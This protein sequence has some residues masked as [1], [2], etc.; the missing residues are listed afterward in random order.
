DKIEEPNDRGIVSTLLFQGAC[1]SS[2]YLRVP[3]GI[4][5]SDI[6]LR[7]VLQIRLDVQGRVPLSGEVPR[8]ANRAFD[9]LLPCCRAPWLVKGVAPLTEIPW[10]RVVQETL[11]IKPGHSSLLSRS[12]TSCQITGKYNV[13]E[14]SK[15]PPR[16]RA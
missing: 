10:W 15:H 14:V 6:C 12:A 16:K 1:D 13:R 8:L 5:E 4:L 7:R 3:D 9:E 11:D 2:E